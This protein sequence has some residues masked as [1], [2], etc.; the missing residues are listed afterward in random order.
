MMHPKDKSSK[1]NSEDEIVH[2]GNISNQD[3]DKDKSLSIDKPRKKREDRPAGK[4][5]QRRDK[6]SDSKI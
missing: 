6:S 2:S 1:R 5:I 4:S 3:L